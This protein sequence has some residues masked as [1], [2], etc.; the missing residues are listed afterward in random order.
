MKKTALLFAL[1]AL[2]LCACAQNN[3]GDS[4]SSA[5]PDSSSSHVL[6]DCAVRFFLD[7]SVVKSLSVKEGSKLTAPSAAELPKGYLVDHWCL[8]SGLKSPW[9][10]ES[11]V[12][13]D[14]DLY[15]SFEYET[16][17]VKLAYS[18]GSTE[19]ETSVSY[20]Q[21]Y[22]FSK[23]YKGK[24]AS[25]LGEE[26]TS[27]DVSGTWLVTHG[28]TLT[29]VFSAQA[30][31]YGYY[32]LLSPLSEGGKAT[33]SKEEISDVTNS[34]PTSLSGGVSDINVALSPA[35]KGGY[36]FEGWYT[37]TSDGGDG[38]SLTWTPTK[39]T[40]LHDGYFGA[41]VCALFSKYHTISL[42][43]NNQTAGTAEFVGDSVTSACVGEEISV[44]AA[45]NAGYTFSG[46]YEGD[47]RLSQDLDYT[48]KMPCKD[49][50]LTAKWAATSYAIAYHLDGGTNNEDNP[51]SYTIE[52][53]VT[54]K[55]PSR[56]GYTFSGWFTDA[57]LSASTT[58]L[59]KGTTGNK[60]FYAKWQG[61][62]Q[63]FSVTYGDHGNASVTSGEGRTG[64]SM[65]VTAAPSDGYILKGWYD[66][67][68]LVST[69]NPYTFTMPAKAYSLKAVFW[70]EAEAKSL[71]AIPTFNTSDGTISFGI[72]PQTYVSDTTTITALDA[73]TAP[74]SNGWYLYNGKYYAK[75]RSNPYSQLY[76]PK[77]SDGNRIIAGQVDYFE[78]KPITWKILTTDVGGINSLVCTVVLDNLAYDEASSD[79]SS[80][81]IRSW[82][83]GS[84]YDTALALGA[85]C[86]KT[87][88]VD[89][90]ASSN[91]STS[92]SYAGGNTKDK[93]YLLSYQDYMGSASFSSDAARVCKATDWA[94]ANGAFFRN[95]DTTH[96][97]FGKAQ[98]WTRSP[99][100]SS[101]A[102]VVSYAGTM[103]NGDVTDGSNSV[104]PG[105]TIK[106]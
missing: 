29:P 46:W 33:T 77:F 83:N 85:S 61:V 78:C 38:S 41:K 96:A 49:L 62:Q 17:T 95:P 15:A 12:T 8:D 32:E 31:S 47:N 81:D 14:L 22:D 36:R 24:A 63:N 74:T 66:G 92:S 23:F 6:A 65:K 44:R 104:R 42:S 98:Y 43:S 48:F 91:E 2:S 4:S 70:T 88:D 86:I 39:I 51:A 5:S 53:E 90:S 94:R 68:D 100:S 80:S 72:Y 67:D 55:D 40:T 73:M 60:D 64:D 93:V 69:S 106:A 57:E 76:E 13:S 87:K 7:G 102:W 1:S 16:Y 52:D 45:A 26:G 21:A 75:T 101:T 99:S 97:D 30:I 35:S 56:N 103:A 37:L 27:Y 25:L 9:S 18:D 20:K 79:Y 50:A 105:I 58:G 34:N 59:S 89:N 19:Y 71:G 84:F 3:G 10:F 82:L 11:A 28:E 54:L